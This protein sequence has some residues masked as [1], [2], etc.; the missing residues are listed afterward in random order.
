LKKLNRKLLIVLLFCCLLA[1]RRSPNDS[2]L[3]GDWTT[4]QIE[5]VSGAE[6]TASIFFVYDGD[7]S[8][9]RGNL[10]WFGKWNTDRGVLTVSFEDSTING[11]YDYKVNNQNQNT[12][13]SKPF[14]ELE[15]TPIEIDDSLF[16]NQFLGT[17]N[18]VY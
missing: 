2:R 16:F 10:S 8:Y 4:I 7:I 18:S 3:Q 12:T 6:I 14:D 9:S 5:Q 13:A 15:L 11:T 1:C 17:F